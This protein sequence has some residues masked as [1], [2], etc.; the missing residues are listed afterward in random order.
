MSRK[1]NVSVLTGEV[2]DSEWKL[3]NTTHNLLKLWRSGSFRARKGRKGLWEYLGS[4]QNRALAPSE[5]GVGVLSELMAG[6]NSC[7]RVPYLRFLQQAL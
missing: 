2:H 6:A 4:W 7:P 3:Q 5:H 1:M